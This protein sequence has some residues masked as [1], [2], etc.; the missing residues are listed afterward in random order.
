MYIGFVKQVKQLLSM[1]LLQ[2]VSSL[3]FED[4]SIYEIEP[5]IL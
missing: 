4:V 3:L 1:R 2:G 5:T